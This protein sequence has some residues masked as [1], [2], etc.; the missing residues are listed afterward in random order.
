[1]GKSNEQNFLKDNLSKQI[2]QE[3]PLWLNRLRTQHSVREDG[4][5][6]PGLAQWVTDL[7]LPQVV[8]QDLVLSWLW[9]R[10]AAAALS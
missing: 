9:Q 4:S 6:I 7:V 8:A 10:Q 2:G 3:F 1:M 5:V